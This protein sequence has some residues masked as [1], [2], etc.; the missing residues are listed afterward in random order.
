MCHCIKKNKAI[1]LLK[2]KKLVQ[3][4]SKPNISKRRRQHIKPLKE[5][6]T[7]LKKQEK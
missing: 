7:P 2:I 3:E 4:Q 1:I 5:G 6:L